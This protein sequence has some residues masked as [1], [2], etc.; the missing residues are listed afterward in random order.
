MSVTLPPE[1]S[2][3][4]VCPERYTLRADCTLDPMNADM[5]PD[6]SGEWVLYEEHSKLVRDMGDLM[7][8]M[9][10]AL[11]E[12]ARLYEDY[13]DAPASERA[14][15]F[16]DARCIARRTLLPEDER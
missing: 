6:P 1:V 7:A 11:S 2:A 9:A 10:N 16:Y 12:I 5:E 13:A 4:R 14:S 8:E 3:V 15:L